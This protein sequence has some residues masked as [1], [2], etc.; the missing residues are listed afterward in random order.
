LVLL[1]LNTIQSAFQVAD[2][3]YKNYQSMHQTEKR[4]S[5]RAQDKNSAGLLSW[6]LPSHQQL[7]KS[8]KNNLPSP[9]RPQEEKKTIKLLE[10]IEQSLNSRKVVQ[11]T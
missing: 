2:T 10:C 6:T 3:Q 5:A 7:I 1:K 11:V 8:L 4:W 9:V